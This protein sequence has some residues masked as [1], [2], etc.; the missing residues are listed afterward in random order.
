[1]NRDLYHNRAPV[2][3]PDLEQIFTLATCSALAGAF[4]ADWYC[5][6]LGLF[7]KDRYFLLVLTGAL[8]LLA[9]VVVRAVAVCFSGEGTEHTRG[10]S[11]WRYV[12][13]LLPVA[14]SFL[15]PTAGLSDPGPAAI[16]V[17][18]GQLEQAARWEKQRAEYEGRTVRLVGRCFSEDN[19]HFILIRHAVPR[20]HLRAVL[21]VDV[22]RSREGAL[23][24]GLNNKWVEVTGQAQFLKSG[25]GD[26]FVPAIVLQPT[27]IK[28]LSQ[29][30]KVV[31]A[32]AN[33]FID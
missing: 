9:L 29:F 23:D 19:E 25:D 21:I 31:P 14:L 30:V 24:A 32:P 3:T 5:D 11:P 27:P 18:L 2:S 33:P 28:N 7:I 8:L 20:G 26:S 16:P 12:V 1:M 17:T 4:I 15:M 6:K 10:W 22:S 13:L